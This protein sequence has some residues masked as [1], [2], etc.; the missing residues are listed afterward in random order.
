MCFQNLPLAGIRLLMGIRRRIK[1]G[2]KKYK[3]QGFLDGL[4][5]EIYVTLIANNKEA[6]PDYSELAMK[7]LKMADAMLKARKEHKLN[8]YTDVLEKYK[9]EQALRHILFM[10]G[11]SDRVIDGM[12]EIHYSDKPDMLRAYA[13]NYLSENSRTAGQVVI[14]RWYANKKEPP[15]IRQ[16]IYAIVKKPEPEPEP[17]YCPDSNL[18]SL[19]DELKRIVEESEKRKKELEQWRKEYPDALDSFMPD[20]Y[21]IKN[22]S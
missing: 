17:E 15:V 21:G 4:A 20:D 5:N 16:R 19:T 2:K 22:A 8:R 9:G 10:D 18:P 13:G 12:I 1:M 6:K 3:E 7:A 14:S 11:N